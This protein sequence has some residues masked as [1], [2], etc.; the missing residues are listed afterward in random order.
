[1]IVENILKS[2]SQ[3]ETCS[4]HQKPVRKTMQ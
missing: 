2:L 3:H 4:F 1:M